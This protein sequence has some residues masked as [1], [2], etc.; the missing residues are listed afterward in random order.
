MLAVEAQRAQLDC[1]WHRG[2]PSSIRRLSRG[3]LN[4]GDE[5]PQE[6]RRPRLQAPG[7]SRRCFGGVGHLAPEVVK[8]TRNRVEV[9]ETRY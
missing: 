1:Y 9:G 7:G 2:L 8:G 5:A 3:R 4:P 6:S